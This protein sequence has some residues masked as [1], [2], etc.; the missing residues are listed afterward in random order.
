ME[1]FLAESGICRLMGSPNG[2]GFL[3]QIHCC[4]T[5]WMQKKAGI[6][7]QGDFSHFFEG[8][9]EYLIFFI[10]KPNQLASPNWNLTRDFSMWTEK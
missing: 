8:N 4:L 2:S 10:A 1:L 6:I 9:L 5:K 7:S 3:L